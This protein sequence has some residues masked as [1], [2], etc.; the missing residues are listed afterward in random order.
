MQI[1][2]RGRQGLIF[3]Y[4]GKPVKDIRD[5]LQSACQKSDILYGCFEK[6]VSFSMISG[7]LFP[8]MPEGQGS[9]GMWP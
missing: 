9:T 4:A 6:K 5:G 1:P 8:Q 3:S 2:E 7:I